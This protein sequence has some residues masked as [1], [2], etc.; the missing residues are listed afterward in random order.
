MKKS[1]SI[2]YLFLICLF[3]NPLHASELI[4]FWHFNHLIPGQTDSISADFSRLTIKPELTYQGSGLGYMD[5]VEGTMLNSKTTELA[6]NGIRTRNPS[7]TRELLIKLPSVGYQNLKL[8]YAVQRSNQGMLKQVIF[9][10][11]NGTDF[12]QFGD[13]ILVNTV[14]ETVEIDFSAIPAAN[15]NLAF[16][17][18][19]KFYDDNTLFNG[20]NRFDNIALEGDAV[21]QAREFIYYWHFNELNTS[22]SDVTSVYTDYNRLENHVSS[23]ARLEY[24]GIGIRDM[25]EFNQG[26]ALNLHEETPAGKAIRVRNPS[27]NRSLILHMSTEYCEDLILSFAAQRSGQGMLY[28]K[29]EYSIDGINYIQNGLKESLF[30]IDEYY[31]LYIIDFSAIPEVNKNPDFKVRITWEGNTTDINGNNR[32][33]N[34]SLSGKTDASIGL[35]K[36]LN[37]GLSAVV[38]PNPASQFVNIQL[39]NEISQSEVIIRDLSGKQIRKFEFNQEKN[40]T[41]DL[42]ELNSGVYLLSIIDISNGNQ[43]TTLLQVQ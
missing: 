38:Y 29:I 20:N 40:M 10:T 30:S 12:T 4:H 23:F 27:D 1:F 25:D 34:I 32:Y 3:T 36:L 15:N 31:Q 41:I 21:E 16:A 6:G 11:I 18:S 26:S 2:I 24:T 19:I 37:K 28:N 5:D 35:E 42:S 8:S 7:D 22:T 39:Q 14:W 13:T 17:V 43:H 33:D 9:Y